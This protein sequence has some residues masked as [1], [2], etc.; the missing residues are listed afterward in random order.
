MAKEKKGRKKVNQKLSKFPE[1]QGSFVFDKS[2]AMV[3]KKS[4]A[5]SSTV[6]SAQ[7][8]RTRQHA[9]RVIESLEQQGFVV[10]KSDKTE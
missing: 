10:R 8:Y 4:E 1:A 5:T 2:P 7:G 6:V 9:K 3:S